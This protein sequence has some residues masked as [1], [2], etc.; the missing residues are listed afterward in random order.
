MKSKKTLTS[1]FLVLFVFAIAFFV[2]NKI[3]FAD[4]YGEISTYDDYSPSY[5][6]YA[7]YSPSYSSYSDYSPSYSDY[8]DYSPS[9]SSY[10][11]Y[12]PSYSDYADY[13]PSYSS[14]SDYSPSYSDYADYSPSYSSYS[15]YSPSYSDYADYS[16][17][18]S[19]YSDYSPSYSDYADYSPS[20]SSY[21]DYSPSYSD[22]A[23]YSPSY[24]SYSDYSPSYS[25]YNDTNTGY[26]SPVADSTPNVGY[27]TPENYSSN[28]GYFNPSSNSANVGYFTPQ[29]NLQT[30][31]N[32]QVQQYGG[33]YSG[34]GSYSQPRPTSVPQSI[35]QPR[36]GYSYPTIPSLPQPQPPRYTPSYPTPAPQPIPQPAPAICSISITP[37]NTTVTRGQAVTLRFTPTSNTSYMTLT[38][39]TYSNTRINSLTTVV[40]PTTSTTYTVRCFTAQGQS[41][42]ATAYVNVTTPYVAPAPQPI[43]YPTPTY[44]TPA[45]CYTCNNNVVIPGLVDYGYNYNYNSNYNNN[46]SYNNNYNNNNY[47]DVSVSTTGAVPLQKSATVYGYLTACGNT[48]VWFDYGTSYNGLQ[49]QTTRDTTSYNGQFSASLTGLSCGTTYY[50][51][52]AAQSG[53]GMKYGNVMSFTTSACSYAP[54]AYN[55]TN[56]SYVDYTDYTPVYT[57]TYTPTYSTPAYVAPVKKT[58]TK[59]VAAPKVTYTKGNVPLEE[60]ET[61]VKCLCENDYMK[62]TVE[63]MENG[64]AA[65]KVANYKVTYKNVG[66][67]TL[68]NIVVRVVVPE[69][70]TIYS[71]DRGQFTKGGKTVLLTIPSL[72]KNEEGS[73]MVAANV[74]TNITNGTQMIV[75]S[76]A[77]YTVPTVVKG[78]TALN[79]EVS[80]YIL[81]SAGSNTGSTGNIDTTLPT[82]IGADNTWLPTNALE[83][84]LTIIALIGLL[85]VIRFIFNSFRSPTI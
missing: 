21:S 14:Y 27:F 57:P 23:D 55:Y 47:C 68:K 46:Y 40:Y 76:Y 56:T 35:S 39:G 75:N 12:S 83:W 34:G 24:S 71:A 85:M 17:S 26:F 45:P 62:I 72:L 6:D 65:G 18:Y 15:D 37:T 51:R 43:P 10:S 1:A 41:N 20:Y 19:S 69:G 50:Y 8:A 64:V 44:Q 81:T 82:S 4:N 22:Y 84:F 29:Q 36:P 79:G 78:G 25:D 67:E 70:M 9:Y 53:Y 61:S 33:G 58:V 16:P 5:S 42:Y 63:A 48:T 52:A 66:T 11:D 13:S 38:G 32:R 80:S 77:N 49:W 30:A 74:A 60:T 54:V 59:T 28:T 31:L 3:V 73:L 2:G 7:D